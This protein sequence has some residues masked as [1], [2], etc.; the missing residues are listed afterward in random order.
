MRKKGHANSDKGRKM[1]QITD[2][3]WPAFLEKARRQADGELARGEIPRFAKSIAARY[4]LKEGSI[5]NKDTVA[6]EVRIG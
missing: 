3:E 1:K 5:Q 2:V 4:G 6:P